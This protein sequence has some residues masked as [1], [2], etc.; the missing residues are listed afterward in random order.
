ME[1]VVIVAAGR[2]PVGKFG[3]SLAKIPAAELGAHV[4]R[5][6]LA[7]TGIDPA[8]ISEVILGQVLT[9][10]VGQN[11]ARQAALK[12]GLPDMVPA[13]TINKVCGSGLKATHLATQAIRCGDAQIV[14]A[15]GQENMSASPHVLPNSRDG[16]R[17]GDTKLVDTM[18][19]DGLWD[20]YNQYHMGVTAEN[21]A[22]KYDISR[23]EQDEFALQSQLK[24]EAAVKEGRFK[25][26]I[27]P[28]EIPSKKGAVVF[29]TDEYPK[30]GSTLEAL[31]SLR[32]AFNKEGTVTAGNASGIND[33]AAAVIMMSASKARELGLT[34]LA[35]IK[36]Y[37]S[38]GLDPS[39]MGM[40]PVSASRLCLQKAGW[41]HEDVDLMEINEAFA[42][43]AIAVNKEM[44]WDTSKINVNGGAI[45][46]GHPIG[47]SGARVLVTLL[48][49]MA[50]RDAKRGL[51]SLCIGGG[52]GV[53]LAVERD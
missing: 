52:M 11:P 7:K 31:S 44:G 10:G 20:V 28:V 6:L 2:T 17:M 3:G 9:A 50:R 51:A 38:A 33:G 12:G 29:D 16:F 21:V 1:D 24:A 8:S 15:G 48:H 45:A 49:E 40:G 25:D 46:L 23:A 27:I 37:S 32:P 26:E 43:Q 41:T 39:I 18:I 4:I 53:A 42:A 5:Q 35:R 36:A 22:R 34:P 13:Y 19:V 14:I 30:H 47:A